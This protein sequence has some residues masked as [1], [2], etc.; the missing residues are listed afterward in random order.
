MVAASA[1]D[2]EGQLP[3]LRSP[4]PG[5]RGS[6]DDA[7][8]LIPDGTL[9]YVT[10]LMATPTDLVGAMAQSFD[11]WTTLATTTDYLL[12]PLATFERPDDVEPERWPFR[13]ITVQPSAATA[14]VEPERLR[15]VPAHSSQ[16]HRLYRPDGPLAVDVALVQVSEPGPDGRFSLGV[17]GGAALE[18]VCEAAI[19]IAEVN[20]DMPYVAGPAAF[21]RHAFDLLIDASH[22]LIT[23]DAPAPDPSPSSV[24][25]RIAAH[26]HELVPDGATIEYGIGAIPDAVVS[27]LSGH[28]N[29]GLHSGLIG[30]AAIALIDA[31]VMDGSA[32]DVDRGLHVASVLIGSRRALEWMRERDDVVIVASGYSHAVP[33]LARHQ[34]FVA[35]NSA[36]EVA[37]DG[38]VNAEQVGTRVVSGPGGQPDFA[39][40]A[41]L[42][43]DSRSVVALPSTAGRGRL[44]RIVGRLGPEV[45]VT[46]PR[47]L[48]DLVVTEHGAASLRG[49]DLA[50]RSRLLSAIADPAFRSELAA[51]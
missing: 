23:L 39:A 2:R 22:P 19:V 8:A 31:G 41:A 14:A 43:R 46:V 25:A 1:L 38:S 45:P 35:V 6:I 7:L 40:G 3:G 21:E 49:V 32:K 30:D 18:V 29:L 10:A 47:Y 51:D 11:R 16:F 26:L 17:G 37:L 48:A 9:V 27:A 36:V 4:R 50:T 12:E 13:H 5:R 33:S 20:P 34:R 28:S 42:G 44:S 15:I 24:P